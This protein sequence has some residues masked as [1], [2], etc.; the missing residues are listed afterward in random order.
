MLLI[1]GENLVRLTPSTAF[2]YSSKDGILP[3]IAE[4]T[5]TGVEANNDS[6]FFRS[7]SATTR[8]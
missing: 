2:S 8:P 5:T 7:E 3:R 4:R 6:P 1:G